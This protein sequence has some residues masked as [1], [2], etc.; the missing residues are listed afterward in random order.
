MR[1]GTVYIIRSHVC[2]LFICHLLK[3]LFFSTYFDNQVTINTQISTFQSSIFHLMTRRYKLV[4]EKSLPYSTDFRC[5]ICKRIQ[6]VAVVHQNLVRF[7]KIAN[8]V[9]VG[10]QS[11]NQRSLL[12]M[13]EILQRCG[14]LVTNGDKMLLLYGTLKKFFTFSGRVLE[15]TKSLPPPPQKKHTVP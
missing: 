7:L 6:K 14:T 1:C 13:L 4:T 3:S 15:W 2:I 9:K 12:K 8:G 10:E 11:L 5:L